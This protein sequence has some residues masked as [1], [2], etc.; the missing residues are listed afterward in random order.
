MHNSTRLGWLLGQYPLSFRCVAPRIPNT[1]RSHLANFHRNRSEF[2]RN[3]SRTLAN[4]ARTN[5][6]QL[7]TAKNDN[8]GLKL[9]EIHVGPKSRT[10]L[11]GNQKR[12][13]KAGG[14]KK[15]RYVVRRCFADSFVHGDAKRYIADHRVMNLNLGASNKVLQV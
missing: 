13:E 11:A 7:E 9:I 2:G 14:V 12:K 5:A 1:N 6:V 4:G 3:T 8:Y 10:Y 15:H